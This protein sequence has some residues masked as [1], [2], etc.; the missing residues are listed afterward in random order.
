MIKQFRLLFPSQ[1]PPHED[2]SEEGLNQDGLWDSVQSVEHLELSDL[3][4]QIAHFMGPGTKGEE[5]L[6][7]A[8]TLGEQ[9]LSHVA[10][11]VSGEYEKA[12]WRHYPNNNCYDGHG[13]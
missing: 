5:I 10:S 4:L 7:R 13:G 9:I 8:R 2:V 11:Q 12:V 1:S 6:S 3:K